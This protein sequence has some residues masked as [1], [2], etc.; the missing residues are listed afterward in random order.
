M[1]IN[2]IIEIDMFFSFIDL[3]DVSCVYVSYPSHISKNDIINKKKKE[4]GKWP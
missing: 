2:R 1:S 4:N 3:F